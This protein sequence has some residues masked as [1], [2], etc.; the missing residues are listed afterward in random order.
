MPA[1]EVKEGKFLMIVE[2]PPGSGNYSIPVQKAPTGEFKI[3][4]QGSSGS[5][6]IYVQKMVAPLVGD[7]WMVPLVESPDGNGELQIEKKH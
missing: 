1:V 5:E 6:T 4:I 2:D 7:K 3:P